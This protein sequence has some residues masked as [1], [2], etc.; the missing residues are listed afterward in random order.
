MSMDLHQ[1]LIRQLSRLG[2]STDV[3]PSDLDQWQGI[4]E[5]ISKAYVEADQEHYLVERAMDVS[6]RELLDLNEKLE[7]SQRLAALGYWSYNRVHEK[8]VLSKTL[9]T[10]FGFKT[11]DPLPNF[12]QFMQ[13]VHEEDRFSLREL[14]EKAFS[15]GVDYECEIR[16]QRPGGELRWYFIIGHPIANEKSG[17]ILTGIAM[18]I[19]KRK[20][21]EEELASLNQQLMMLSRQIGMAD[22]ASSTLHNVGNVLSSAC[23]SADLLKEKTEQNNYKKFFQVINLLKEHQ[24]SLLNYLNQDPKGQL[25]P[26]YLISLAEYLEED[27]KEF[28][29][30]IEVIRSQLQHI[31]DIVSTQKEISRSGGMT[32]KVILAD[33]IDSALQLTGISLKNKDI[34]IKKDYEIMHPIFLDKNKLLQILVNLIKNAKEAFNSNTQITNKKITISAQQNSDTKEVIIVVQDN[35]IGI[36]NEHL[37]KIF[38][39]GFTTKETGLGFGL[40]SSALTAQEM[41]GKISAESKGN[42][43]GAIFTLSFPLKQAQ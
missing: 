11:G 18:D 37:Q 34:I 14:I 24:S 26:E 41:G 33:V 8:I 31:K 21:T 2:L 28:I 43:K 30:E 32:E 27:H 9:Y 12:E 7:T 1:L 25:I 15:E 40:H 16:M 39:F 3:L 38:S 29:K 10:L 20:K 19:T 22:I 17:Y 23:V 36:I 6:S 13:M 5:K 42:G 35:G 4:L